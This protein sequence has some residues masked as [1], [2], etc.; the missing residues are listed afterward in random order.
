MM[1]PDGR[2]RLVGRLADVIRTGA[3]KVMSSEVEGVLQTHHCVE[4]A[5]VV[6]MP[7]DVFGEKVVAVVVLK[8]G[9]GDE[10]GAVKEELVR[11]CRRHLAGFKVPR[12][13]EFRHVLPATGSG[14]VNKHMVR[15]GLRKGSQESKASGLPAG[16]RSAL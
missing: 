14:K 5:A 15:A 11:H 6:G 1:D 7:D 8:E 3:E 12:E 9:A 2:F 10:Q 13:F 4:S 16:L